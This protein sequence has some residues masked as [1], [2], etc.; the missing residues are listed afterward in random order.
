M[1]G[2]HG[3]FHSLG[4]PERRRRRLP[5]AQSGCPYDDG[6]RFTAAVSHEPPWDVARCLEVEVTRQGESFDVALDNLREALELHFE[7]QAFPEGIEPPIIAPA[8][9]PV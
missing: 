2:T 4:E 9:I 5:P 6:V 1:A 8:D 3:S 7:D